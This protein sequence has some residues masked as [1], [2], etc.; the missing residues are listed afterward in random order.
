MALSNQRG[1]TALPE[2]GPDHEGGGARQRF[3][4]TTGRTPR[5]HDTRLWTPTGR[6]KPFF[7]IGLKPLLPITEIWYIIG[8]SLIPLKREIEEVRPTGKEM[9]MKLKLLTK[10]TTDDLIGLFVIIAIVI[11]WLW[12]VQP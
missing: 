6:A 4:Q 2:T 10:K 9:D 7:I 1:R 8:N 11:A 12:V 5:L 3:W